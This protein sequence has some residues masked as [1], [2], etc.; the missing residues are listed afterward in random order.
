MAT[1]SI[2]GFLGGLAAIVA[3]VAAVSMVGPRLTRDTPLDLTGTWRVADVVRRGPYKTWRFEYELRL[4]QDGDA[5]SGG[6]TVVAVNGR[7]PRPGEA[8]RIE[9][10]RGLIDQ[11][12]VLGWYTETGDGLDARGAYR[13]RVEDADTLIGT[14][15]TTVSAGVSSARR[16]PA[17]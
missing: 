13:W 2:T 17:R 10:V 6:G 3:M 5:F 1:R 12:V 7:A 14:F 9:I 4:V 8:G 15:A 16:L 11:R